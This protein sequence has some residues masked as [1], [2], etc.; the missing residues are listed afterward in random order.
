MF[1]ILVWGRAFQA[2][3]RA[4]NDNGGGVRYLDV[5]EAYDRGYAEKELASLHAQEA[6][7]WLRR[8]LVLDHAYR[9]NLRATAPA[10]SRVRQ[11]GVR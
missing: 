1:D 7:R 6:E 4:R 2:K 5:K 9:L 3:M 11:G 8:A 10:V